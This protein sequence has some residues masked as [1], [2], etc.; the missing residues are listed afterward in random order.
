[1][2]RGVE[3]FMVNNF[4]DGYKHECIK[5]FLNQH[6]QQTQ[7]GIRASLEKQL[8]KYQEHFISWSDIIINVFSWNCA[9]N[10]PNATFDISNLLLP[11][12]PSIVP[13]LYVVGLQEMVKLNAKSVIQGKDRE[14]AML[15]E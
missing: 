1:M 8:E 9:G 10:T 14:K 13:D 4:E 6:P 2:R 7:Y 3:R 11:E 5:L 12:D 15:W